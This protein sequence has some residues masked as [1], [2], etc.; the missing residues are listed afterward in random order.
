MV[1]DAAEPIV[2][3][4]LVAVG[5]DVAINFLSSKSAS[6]YPEPGGA[7]TVSNKTISSSDI[8]C[9]EGKVIVTDVV[10]SVEKSQPAIVLLMG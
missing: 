9:T 6:V 7:V 10:A 1:P 3:V 5:I 4:I 8:P 2:T